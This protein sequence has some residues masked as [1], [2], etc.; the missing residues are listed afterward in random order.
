MLL[1][2]VGQ[3]SNFLVPYTSRIRATPEESQ[4]R[5]E[6]NCVACMTDSHPIFRR[7]RGILLINDQIGFC[8][9]RHRKFGEIL[10]T[11]AARWHIL[12]YTLLKSGLSKSK[13][14]AAKNEIQLDILGKH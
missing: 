2:N 9:T 10:S 4:R 6:N 7:Q 1:T 13:Q 11:F 8:V 3:F 14:V 12:V 5:T